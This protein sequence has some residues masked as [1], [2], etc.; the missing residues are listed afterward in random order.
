MAEEKP[1]EQPQQTAAPKEE[2]A[3][4]GAKKKRK[5]INEMTLKDVDKKLDEVKEKMGN[6]SSK[7]AKDLLKRKKE[8]SENPQP[9]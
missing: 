6:L 7:Y 5:K 3:A 8:L 1:K 9:Q 2:A 4:A